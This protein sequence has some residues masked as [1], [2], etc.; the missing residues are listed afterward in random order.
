M[1]QKGQ[2]Y[3]VVSFVLVIIMAGVAFTSRTAPHH[4]TEGHFLMENM[5]RELPLSYAAGDYQGDMNSVLSGIASEFREFSKAKGYQN[6][7]IFSAEETVGAAVFYHVGNWSG[8]GCT[9][10]NTKV[11]PLPIA[12]GETIYR[13]RAWFQ[14]DYDVTVCGHVLDLT[15]DFDYRAEVRREGELIVNG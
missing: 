1:N 3:L 6:M 12:D 8:E 9:Y 15:E 2:S 11:G 13:P 7:L 5:E 10:Y 4:R 14:N